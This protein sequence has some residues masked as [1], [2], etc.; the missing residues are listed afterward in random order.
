MKFREKCFNLLKSLIWVMNYISIGLL[1]GMLLFF[2]YKQI[3]NWSNALWKYI[4][5]KSK[6]IVYR[7]PVIIEVNKDGKIIY[8]ND[9]EEWLTLSNNF[10]QKNG[11]E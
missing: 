7:S 4:N 2:T 1:L 11:D 6:V 5:V 10:D 8:Y 3:D 9:L